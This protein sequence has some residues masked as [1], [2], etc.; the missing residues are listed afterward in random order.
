MDR[1]A[2]VN[3]DL[4]RLIEFIDSQVYAKTQR[5]LKDVEVLI[6]QGSWQKQN[7]DEIALCHNYTP[8]YLRQ[9]VGP[10]LWRR[11][12]TVLGERVSKTS[13][14]AAIE[15]HWR[16]KLAEDQA[17]ATKI[18]SLSPS[19]TASASATQTPVTPA[20]RTTTQD[21]GEAVD[22]SAFYGRSQ[23]VSTLSQ[24]ICHDHCRLVCVLGMG[25]IGKTSLAIKLGQQVSPYYDYLIW[26]SLRQGPSVDHFLSDLIQFLSDQQEV[27]LPSTL[28]GKVSRLMHFLRENRC[29]LVLDNLESLLESG[30]QAG[31]Y[32]PEFEGY[33]YL[34][35]SIG[36]ISHQSCLIL[37]SREKTREIALMEGPALPVRT[38]TLQGLTQTEGRGIFVQKGCIGIDDQ[39]LGIIFDH[40]AGNPLALNIL[41]SAVKDL[42]AGNVSDVIPYLQQ[43][44]LQFQDISDLLERQFERLLE[45]EQ[46]ILYWLTLN[47]EPITLMELAENIAADALPQTLLEAVQSLG[48]RCLIEQS[49]QGLSLQPVVMEFVTQRIVEQVA[50]ELK[51]LRFNLL[52]HYPLLLA[53]GRDYVRQAQTQYLLR[54][55]LELLAIQ[56]ETL[57]TPENHLKTA[58]SRLREQAHPTPNYAAGNLLNLLCEAGA[59]LTHVDCSHLTVWQAYLNNIPLHGANFAGSDLAK[60]SFTSTLSAAICVTFNADGSLFAIG[61]ADNTI[62]IYRTKNF[63]ELMTL[64]GHLSWVCALA[65]SPDG[66]TLASGS[67]DHAIKLWNVE[68]GLCERTLLG[69]TGWVWDVNFS[70]DGQTLVSGQTLATNQPEQNIRLWDVATGECTQ[71]LTGHKGWVWSVSFSPNGQQLVS[72]GD[73]HQIRLWDSTTGKTLAVWTGHTSWVRSVAFSPDGQTVVSGSLDGTI[74]VWQVGTGV[75]LHVLKGHRHMVSSV[76]F[77]PVLTPSKLADDV[78]IASASSDHTVRIWNL[79]TGQCI[80]VLRGHTSGIWSVAIHPQGQILA[81]A[82]NDCTVRLWQPQTGQSIQTLQGFGFGIKT[83]I[84]GPPGS[85]SLITGGDDKTIKYW[86]LA[87]GHC[88]KVLAGHESWVWSVALSPDCKTLASSSNDSSIRIWD[89]K[90]GQL[91]RVLQGHLNVALSVAFSPDGLRVASGSNDQTIKIWEPKTGACLQ[92]YTLKHRVWS[93]TFSPDGQYL[94]SGHDDEMVRIW[95]VQTGE[96]AYELKGHTNLVFTVSFSADGTYLAS[97]S[98]DGLAK[99]W[100]LKTG[101]CIQTLTGHLATVWS[102]QFSPDGTLAATSSF[103]QTIRIWALANG[104]CLKTLTGHRGEVWKVLFGPHPGQLLSVGQDGIIKIWNLET[105]ACDRTIREARLYEGMNIAAAK[106][107]TPS[108]HK[109]LCALGAVG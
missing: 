80:K 7:Y 28:E 9:D 14:Q 56:L 51:D 66:N 52:L 70:P 31:R 20:P 13:F 109:A 67:F 106:G 41:A 93:V 57:N 49:G 1:Q 85:Q 60:S 99:I 12:S 72:G 78:H 68:R 34:F 65:F 23:E 19:L 40:Y 45:M 79:T 6:L 83:V 50:E 84:L 26:R 29:L 73:D 94:A 11:L 91:Q 18:T 36:E 105:G 4:D 30:T 108:Q 100:S 42:T 88:T 62:R 69:H 102:V 101:A 81:S 8:Q 38:L 97:G 76:V 59:D 3:L 44:F 95:D 107:L 87:S 43:G 24:W 47:R 82:A 103:D 48:R 92:T 53:Q 74:R 63:Q 98:E 39:S 10:K 16:A 77:L 61:G 86:D 54:P 35:R 37:T 58:L 2:L 25:G 64:E 89:A 104:Q 75:C 32:S 90:T 15:R 27:E 5:H 55:V 71:T 21:W 46:Q 22:V 17:A 96:C 33:G